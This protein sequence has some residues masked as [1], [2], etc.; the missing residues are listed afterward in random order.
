MDSRLTRLQEAASSTNRRQRI[1]P[2]IVD[3]ERGAGDL[4][5]DRQQI[6]ELALKRQEE[7]EAVIN[8]GRGM[9]QHAI[10]PQNETKPRSG[11]AS[12]SET[13]LRPSFVAKHSRD[14]IAAREAELQREAE[15]NDTFAAKEERHQRAREMV[16]DYINKDLEAERRRREEAL[17]ATDA[18]DPLSV[19]DTDGLDPEMEHLE[20]TLRHLERMKRDKE[21][22]EQVERERVELE[23]VRGLTE[24]ERRRMDEEKERE[25]AS[26]QPRTQMK[27]MQ[28]YY[29]KGAFFQDTKDPLF[30][31]DYNQPT[32]QDRHDKEV[33]PGV[34]QARD[35]FGKRSKSKWTHLTAE[36]TTSFEY[37]WGSKDN[38]TN[39]ESISRMGGMRG[40]TSDNHSTTKKSKQQ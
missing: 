32:L 6:K 22:R 13:G 16:A 31:R 26:N 38:P 29:H 12:K 35:F 19:D 9:N 36:D 21:E 27:F 24:E 30:E 3:G 39:Y 5:K 2:Q 1:T 4:V 40:S 37:G 11:D 34:M 15:I 23:R 10:K 17:H 25:W 8:E 20:W 14:T 33:L 18:F 28:K 7:E